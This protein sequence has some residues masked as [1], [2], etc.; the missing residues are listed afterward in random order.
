MLSDKLGKFWKLADAIVDEEDLTTSAHLEL[1][2]FG[3]DFRIKG[4][5]L[6]LNGI[7]IR[8]RRLD[9]T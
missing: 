7:A 2:G 9:N 3:Y 6:S 8:R 1:D 4:T 5:K